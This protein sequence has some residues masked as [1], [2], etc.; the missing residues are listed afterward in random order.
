MIVQDYDFRKG[1]VRTY[2]DL[3]YYIVR[4]DGAVFDEAIERENNVRCYTESTEK[5]EDNRNPI[6]T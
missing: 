3:G 4:D 2:S 6:S 1:F 5:I